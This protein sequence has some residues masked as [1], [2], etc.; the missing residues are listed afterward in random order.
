MSNELPLLVHGFMLGRTAVAFRELLKQYPSS[1]IEMGRATDIAALA[2]RLTVSQS[3]ALTDP[4][5]V[6][7]LAVMHAARLGA[8]AATSD[9]VPLKFGTFASSVTAV[10]D[11]CD[12]A[13]PQVRAALARISGKVE[14]GVRITVRAAPATEVAEEAESGRDYL[15]SRVTKRARERQSSD[16]RI[17][18]AA[19]VW[20]ALAKTCAEQQVRSDDAVTSGALLLKAACLV[21]RRRIDEF[22]AGVAAHEAEAHRLSLE[23][24]VTGAW[25]AF[26][27]VAAAEG[28][29]LA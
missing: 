21:E 3:S 10:S 11:I 9:I 8:V 16:S 2:S 24:V 18:F 14:F 26:S 7:E 13:A 27:F 1:L 17:G 4:E 15:R 22:L 6:T 20:A 28:Q 5:A 23:L 12:G 29:H 19:D 25:P